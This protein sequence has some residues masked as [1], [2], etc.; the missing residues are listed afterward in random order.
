MDVGQS[1]RQS[2]QGTDASSVL[3]LGQWFPNLYA[4]LGS[5]VHMIQTLPLTKFPSCF[6][7]QCSVAVS[8]PTI[9]RYSPGQGFQDRP[10]HWL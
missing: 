3:A 10:A 6:I 5:W 7:L 8:F 2:F 9:K 1:S 4:L